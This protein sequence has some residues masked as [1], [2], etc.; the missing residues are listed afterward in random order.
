MRITFDDVSA[1]DEKTGVILIVYNIFKKWI[2]REA[3]TD[4]RTD[5]LMVCEIANALIDAGLV[6]CTQELTA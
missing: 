3:A 6:S 2:D 1:C 4:D 5:D